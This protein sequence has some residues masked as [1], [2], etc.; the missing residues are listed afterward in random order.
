MT[1]T[2]DHAGAVQIAQ[3]DLRQ[4]RGDRVAD[5]QARR[6]VAA[7]ARRYAFVEHAEL[8]ALRAVAEAA[9]VLVKVLPAGAAPRTADRAA[10]RLCAALDALPPADGAPAPPQGE[11]V[12]RLTAWSQNVCAEGHLD[13]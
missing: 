12:E 9:R 5:G 8:A 13:G 2:P 11:D 6:V 10:D 1:D 7:L 4:H 3:E